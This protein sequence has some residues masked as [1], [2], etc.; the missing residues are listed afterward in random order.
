VRGEVTPPGQPP[1]EGPDLRVPS[2]FEIPNLIGG[3]PDLGGLSKNW[4]V[5]L[6]NLL[7]AIILLLVMFTSSSVFNE[8]LSEHRLELQGFFHRMMA[9]FAF[10]RAGVQR[11]EPPGYVVAF[12]ERVLGPILVLGTAALIYSFSNPD[13]GFNGETALVYSSLI[14]SMAIMTYL[15]EGGEALITNRRFGVPAAVRLFPF[16]LFIAVAFTI[17]TRLVD[18]D[19]PVMFG[20]VATATVLGATGLDE[21]KAASS[22]LLPSLGLLAVSVAAWLLLDPLRGM[23]DSEHWWAAIPEATAAL[24]FVGGI[25]GLLFVMV[26]FSFTDGSKLFRWYKLWWVLIVGV[27]GFLFC[28]V[29]LNPQAAALDAVLERRVIFI[30]ALVAAYA[31][32]AFLFWLY[33]RTRDV[34]L[35]K[36]A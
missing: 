12:L 30:C 32:A 14:I 3:I 6:T 7:L 20:F 13:V 31:L 10:I 34:R 28:W 33:F 5:A 21:K 26:P 19:A 2:R 25:E 11:I 24:I 15:A 35:G 23:S 22:V 8:T 29:I 16:A 1:D 9:P 4:K 27:S 17:T 36:L 18:F